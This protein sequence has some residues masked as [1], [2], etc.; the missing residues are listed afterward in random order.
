L[1]PTLTIYESFFEVLVKEKGENTGLTPPLYRNQPLYNAL[2][3]AFSDINTIKEII[4]PKGIGFFL[5]F[6]R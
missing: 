5:F 2:F 6:F 1:Q 4:P 3:F